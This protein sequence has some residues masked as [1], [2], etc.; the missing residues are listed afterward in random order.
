MRL[1]EATPLSSQATASP[2]QRSSLRQSEAF[3]TRPSGLAAPE[4]QPD[5]GD[6]EVLAHRRVRLD[7]GDQEVLA[8]RRVRLGPGDQEVLAHRRVRLGRAAL[9]VRRHSR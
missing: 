1:N 6:Q 8:H 7:P 5:P 9:V 2:P 4:D 3:S